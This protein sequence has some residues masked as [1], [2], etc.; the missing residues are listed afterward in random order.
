MSLDSA[1]AF[2][3][4]V[5]HRGLEAHLAHFQSIA[6]RNFGDIAFASAYAPGGDEALFASASSCADF[7]TLTTST[8][9][10]SAACTGKLL[11]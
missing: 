5:I 10:A 8:S 3:E 1:A 11:L 6:W 7:V 2:N 4:R 9:R